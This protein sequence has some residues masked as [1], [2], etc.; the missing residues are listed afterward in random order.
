MLLFSLTLII[1]VSFSAAFYKPLVETNESET[2]E[3][4]ECLGLGL[5]QMEAMKCKDVGIEKIKNIDQ[6][7]LNNHPSDLS[8]SD[9][10]IVCCV[11]ADS[12]NCIL[13]IMKQ[14]PGC[15][16]KYS[17]RTQKRMRESE[18]YLKT[19]VPKYENPQDCNN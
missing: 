6:D 11:I 17:I 2:K 14:F 5:P 3:L 10:K 12:Q 16:Q 7:V 19:C 4:L 13:E 18:K 9:K 8:D 15:A 1:G